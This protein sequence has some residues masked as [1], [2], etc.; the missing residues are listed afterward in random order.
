MLA[1][2]FIMA[3]PEASA[4]ATTYLMGFL[5][6]ASGITKL[7]MTAEIGPNLGV[8]WMYL[9]AS[10]SILL[11][12]MVVSSWPNGAIEFLGFMVSLELISAG[13]TYINIGAAVKETEQQIYQAT[14]RTQRIDKKQHNKSSHYESFFI[15]NFY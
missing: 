2:L 7:V 15:A 13:V 3:I 8:G 9:S 10:L 4:A 14:A 12:A 1:G 5:F 11:G 6:I